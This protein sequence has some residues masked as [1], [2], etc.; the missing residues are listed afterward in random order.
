MSCQ[1]Q[2]ASRWPTDG[3]GSQH[4]DL[5]PDGGIQGL[6][7]QVHGQEC[8]GQHHPWV[9]QA[10]EAAPVLHQRRGATAQPSSRKGRRPH[11]APPQPQDPLVSGPK[12][13]KVNNCLPN[14]IFESLKFQCLKFQT[15]KFQCLKFQTLEFLVH[16]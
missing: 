13:F 10:N 16:D 3:P 15:L 12:S 11:Q 4:E 5:G 9:I 7:H 2:K 14:L 8:W 6:N 1:L